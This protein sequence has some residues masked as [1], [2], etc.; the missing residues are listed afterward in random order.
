[1]ADETTAKAGNSAAESFP[2][3]LLPFSLPADQRAALFSAYA[4]PPRAYHHIGHVGEVLRHYAMVAQEVGWRR[5]HEVAWAVLYHDAVYRAGRK[6]NESESAKLVL[7]HLDRWPAL[8]NVDRARI[9]AL[10]ELTAQHGRLRRETF[11][12][13][14]DAARHAEDT[15]HFLDCDM[16]ILGAPEPQF[17]DYDR[18]IA[19]EYRALPRWLY[20]HKR[21]QFFRMLLDSER[22]FLSDL[23]RDRFESQAR[24][25]LARSLAVS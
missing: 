11:L 9:S 14:A 6:D 8:E 4:Q 12:A 7:A 25:N 3:H 20:R 17:A 15:L 1:V 10:I 16:A 13:A 2:E 23:F 5:P 18:A 24:K 19:E 21:R 22:I